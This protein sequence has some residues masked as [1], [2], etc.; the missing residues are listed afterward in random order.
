VKQL[1]FETK[2]HAVFRGSWGKLLQ[3]AIE[4]IQKEVTQITL[5]ATGMAQ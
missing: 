2:A 3:K 4:E 1:E 5:L